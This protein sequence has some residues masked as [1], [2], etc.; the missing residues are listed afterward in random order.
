MDEGTAVLFGVE[1]RGSVEGLKEGAMES[2]L[3]DEGLFP[4]FKNP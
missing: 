1:A 3:R 4:P 2:K